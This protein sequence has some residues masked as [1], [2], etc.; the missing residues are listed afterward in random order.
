MLC[1]GELGGQVI[2]R[3]DAGREGAGRRK[4]VAADAGFP[5]YRGLQSHSPCLFTLRRRGADRFLHT[6][7]VG[8]LALLS[9]SVMR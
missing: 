2:Y 3:R 9:C 6:G 7:P 5:G 1:C 8:H 4:Q